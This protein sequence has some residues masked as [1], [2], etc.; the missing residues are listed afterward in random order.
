MD[1]DPCDHCRA[2]FS[3]TPGNLGWS[4]ACPDDPPKN[5]Q[6]GRGATPE[7]A[8]EDFC[9]KTGPPAHHPTDWARDFFLGSR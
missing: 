4:F 5:K 7:E 3:L 6:I 1:E 8:Y 9:Q 2:T